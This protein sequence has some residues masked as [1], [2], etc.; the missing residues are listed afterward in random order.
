MIPFLFFKSIYH[1][2]KINFMRKFKADF[3]VI[4]RPLIVLFIVMSY[5]RSTAQDNHIHTVDCSHAFLIE[6]AN[7]TIEYGRSINILAINSNNVQMS[8]TLTGGNKNISGNGSET[9]LQ[10]FETPGIY[11]V[12]FS[13]QPSANFPAHS[14]TI[15]IVVKDVSML[16]D[17]AAAQPSQTIYSGQSTEGLFITIPVIIKTY[18]GNQV[19]FGPFKSASTGIDGISITYDEQISLAPGKHNLKFKLHGTP[20]GSGPCQIRFYNSIGEG[21]FYNFLISK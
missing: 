2:I 19:N 12:I 8:W 17:V 4:K 13:S 7:Y 10:L 21:F 14:E 11:K 9:G 18:N 1:F 15:E 16:F 3:W 5:L 20:A 6:R